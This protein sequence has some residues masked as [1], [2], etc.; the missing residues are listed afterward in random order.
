MLYPSIDTLMEKIDSK[1]SLVCLAAKRAR[2]IQDGDK[3][4]LEKYKC[5]KPVGKA[6]EEIAQDKLTFVVGGQKKGND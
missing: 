5:V 6:L 2:K 3:L 1:Y 4:Y